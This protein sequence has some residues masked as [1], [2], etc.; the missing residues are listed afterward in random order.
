[1]KLVDVIKTRNGLSY[2]G[3]NLELIK[4]NDVIK[5]SREVKGYDEN[6]KYTIN[7]FSYKKYV[8]NSFKCLDGSIEYVVDIISNYKIK[9]TL[10]NKIFKF[11]GDFIKLEKGIISYQPYNKIQEYD[12]RGNWVDKGRQEISVFK[13]LTKI[14]GEIVEEKIIRESAEEL[15]STDKKFELSFVDGEDIGHMYNKINADNWAYDSCMAGKPKC[16][17]DLYSDN[18]KVCKLGIVKEE[19]EIVGRA[20][21]WWNECEKEWCADKLYCKNPFVYQWFKNKCKEDKIPSVINNT[22]PDDISIVLCNRVDSYDHLPYMDSIIYSEG[23]EVISTYGNGTQ[24]QHQRGL[25][26]YELKEYYEE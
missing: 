8:E 1:M 24:L 16:Y 13:F 4:P 25:D 7:N 19:E 10:K 3:N 5:L 6:T 2:L 22:F 15:I 9:N 11:S 14:F 18:F 12:N 26:F 17:F 21:F 23:D 20:I